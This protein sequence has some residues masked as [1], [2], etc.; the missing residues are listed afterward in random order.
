MALGLVREGLLHNVASDAQGYFTIDNVRFRRRP[1]HPEYRGSDDSVPLDV[2]VV[3]SHPARKGRS[4][5]GVAGLLAR[6][7]RRWAAGQAIVLGEALTPADPR[8][9][10]P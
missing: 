10:T 2:D 1:D 9:R 7:A 8:P 4:R 6:A 5:V 3:G